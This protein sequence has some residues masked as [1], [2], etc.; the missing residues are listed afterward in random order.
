MQV[1]VFASQKGGSGKSTLAGHVAVQAELM[2][3]GPVGLI[4]T[5]PQG[6]LTAW[7]EVRLADTPRFV[8]STE[9]R[10][11][12]DVQKLRLAGIKL[13]VIDTPPAITSTIGRVIE[14][15]D[16]VVIPTRPSPHDLR[17]VGATVALAEGLGKPL[18][19][20]INGATP[21]ARITAEAAIAL[22]EH[23]TAAPAVVHQRVGFAAS[24]IDGRTVLEQRGNPRSPAE[25]AELW[26]FLKAR[27]ARRR[28]NGKPA[29]K[30]TAVKARAT[31]S[32][33]KKAA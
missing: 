13:L 28:R 29:H 14:L 15:A 8:H 12:R 7:H 17:A 27:L 22:S 19:F 3:G 32:V 9:R 18:V 23:G 5:D 11:T 25:I 26:R 33:T 2:G 6:S 4:D 30:A 24:M 20:V 10:L 16:L 21:R 31:R 1:L